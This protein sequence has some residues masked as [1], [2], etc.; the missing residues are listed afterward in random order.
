MYAFVQQSGNNAVMIFRF[1]NSD[2][3]IETLQK[4]GFTILE[5]KQLYSL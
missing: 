4:E 3:A 5:S 1:D 2:E